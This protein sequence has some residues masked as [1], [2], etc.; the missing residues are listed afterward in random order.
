MEEKPQ[1]QGRSTRKSQGS[2]TAGQ[3]CG[4]AQIREWG[5]ASRRRCFSTEFDGYR[6]SLQEAE[7]GDKNRAVVFS[8]VIQR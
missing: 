7:A 1:H 5:K 4:L 6:M 2:M 8:H 3:P